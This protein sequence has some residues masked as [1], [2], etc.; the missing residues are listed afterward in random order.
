MRNL[1]AWCASKQFILLVLFAP[2]LLTPYSAWTQADRKIESQ[3]TQAVGPAIEMSNVLFRYTDQITVLIS[4]LRGKLV[5]T[6]GYLLPDFNHPDSFVIEVESSQISMTTEQLAALMN[7]RLLSSPKAQ[8]KAVRILSEGDRLQIKGTMKKG[9]HIPFTAEAQVSLSGDNRIRFEIQQMKAGPAPIKG[10]MEAFGL[11]V[12]DLVSQK[13]MTGIAIDHDSFLV[14]PQTAFPFPQLKAKLT[15]VQVIGN[16]VIITSG[17]GSPKLGS[18]PHRNFIA[19]RGG[20][21]RY[22]R[23]EMHDV[24]LVLYDSTPEDPFDFFLGE[25]VRQ[26][27]SGYVKVTE[28][29][30]LRGYVRDFAKIGRAK[31]VAR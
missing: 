2:S 12:E 13:G 31:V 11:Q 15:R 19:L 22:G 6:K 29:M 26:F 21:L 5:P 28:S 7:G 16:K 1:L 20:N 4:S 23:E 18:Q 8:I 3:K 30:A 27:Q 10:V 25:Y 24:D 9:L 14:D 17:A